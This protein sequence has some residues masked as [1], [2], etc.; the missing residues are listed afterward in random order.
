[1]DDL[2][3]CPFCGAKAELRNSKWANK[4][5]Y[6]VT[7]TDCAVWF[8]ERADHGAEAIA[9]WNTRAP[10]PR[11]AEVE[12]ERDGLLQLVKSAND[13]FQHCEVSVG[14]CCCGN[15]VESHGYGDGH[16]PVDQGAYST[17]QWQDEARQALGAKP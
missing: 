13:I 10:D 8:D 15:P 3:P 4:D 16:S 14:Y 9:A 17:M 1:M 6:G 2:K 11:L 12:A 7:C 5:H